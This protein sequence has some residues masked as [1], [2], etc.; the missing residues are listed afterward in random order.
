MAMLNVINSKKHEVI[1]GD[2][3]IGGG[4][5]GSTSKAVST[6]VVQ[7]GLVNDNVRRFTRQLEH[8]RVKL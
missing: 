2:E 6:V 7:E 4:G 3:V 8:S 1:G 5:N